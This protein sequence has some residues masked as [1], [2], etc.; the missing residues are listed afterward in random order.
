MMTKE[1]LEK[2]DLQGKLHWNT[3][4]RPNR[5]VFLDEYRGQ[6]VENLWTDIFV[7]NPMAN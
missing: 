3:R 4:G 5:R 2:M 6:P 1:K 7:I